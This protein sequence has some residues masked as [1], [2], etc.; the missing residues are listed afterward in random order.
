MSNFHPLEVVRRDSEKQIHVG[1]GGYNL[2]LL[3]LFNPSG[4]WCY[5]SR[6][7]A[8]SQR[9]FGCWMIFGLIV[10]VLCNLRLRIPESSVEAR[11]FRR[12]FTGVC[13]FFS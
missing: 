3:Y 7:W 9:N 10:I 6:L 5:N 11:G 13:L 2:Y 4:D 12:L 8:F 1:G